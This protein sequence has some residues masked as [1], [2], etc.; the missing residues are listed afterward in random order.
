MFSAKFGRIGFRR[1]FT[2]DGV[3]RGKAYKTKQV[4]AYGVKENNDII[5]ATVLVK[6]F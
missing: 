4:E 2:F 3:W 5:I 1:N 6:Y